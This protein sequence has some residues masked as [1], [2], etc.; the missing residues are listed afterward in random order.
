MDRR[1]ILN[2]QAHGDMVQRLFALASFVE[3][4]NVVY[5]F[6]LVNDIGTNHALFYEEYALVLERDGR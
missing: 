1:E 2:L 5:K 4:P 6:M 3:K